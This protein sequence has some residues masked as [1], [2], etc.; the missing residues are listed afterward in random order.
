MSGIEFRG[1]TKTYPL[2]HHAF[3]GIKDLVV[4]FPRAFRS[5]RENSYTALKDVNFSVGNGEVLGVI[6]KNG[7]G[8][9]TLLSL[10]AGVMKPS[11]GTVSVEG[12]VFPMLE[13][14]GG[15]HPDLTG[16]ENIELNAV[17]L[18]LS[19]KE[20]R[21]RYQEIAEFAEL[22][23]FMLEPMRIYSSGMKAKLGFSVLANL[24]PDILIIDEVLAVG[25]YEFQQKC[26]DTM[27][28]FKR[29]GVTMLFVSHSMGDIR[30]IC[31][32]VL[33]LHD[34][35]VS[36]EAGVEDAISHYENLG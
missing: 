16:K 23:D 20:I 17:L 14:G 34:H 21:S 32:R 4:N 28:K 12:R 27:E 15:F 30:R 29:K 22:G 35:K 26:F 2:Y 11:H 13:L 5:L 7:A 19:R 31:D 33:V 36:L 10:A 9:S 1:V 24:D 8:K 25:D 18:G 3:G 6:G